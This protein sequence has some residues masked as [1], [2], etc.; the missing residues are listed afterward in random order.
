M[1]TKNLVL[2]CIRHRDNPKIPLMFRAV[3]AVNEKLINHFKLK[4]LENDWEKMIEILGADI[5][6]DG[7]TLGA[8]TTYIPKYAGP[9]FEAI[10]EPNHF[11][12]WGIKPE[13][14]YLGSGREIIFHKNPPLAKIETPDELRKYKFPETGWFDFGTYK[15]VVTAKKESFEEQKEIN[16]QFLKR[17]DIYFINTFCFNSIFM[18]S[19]FMRGF[20]NMLMDLLSNRFFAKTL[21][22]KIGEFYLD[23]TIK[24][25]DAIG[26][27]LDL[28]GIW[29]DF[30]AILE[31]IVEQSVKDNSNL[32]INKV[33]A[34][35][36]FRICEIGY[37][38]NAYFKEKEEELTPKKK[39][40]AMA[41]GRDCGLRKLDESSETAF[42]D[43]YKNDSHCGGHPWEICRGGNST[44]V[45]LYLYQ[46]ENG[47]KLRLA[48]SSR[49]RVVETVKMALAFYLNKIPFIL[50]K[51]EEILRMITGIDFIGIV[52]ETIIPRYCYGF[53]PDDNRIN[54]FMNLGFE[55]AK[56]IIEKSY[57][58]PIKEVRLIT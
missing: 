48:G 27:R 18:T 34:G 15:R 12:I 40:L 22:D 5:F 53:F 9:S 3:P 7:E 46:V 30:V 56:E 51:A 6:S 8:F 16:P 23:F 42:A 35:D 25:L 55:R 38:A 37:N 13:Y 50:E 52:P 45:S 33:S 58:Y 11:F 20:E 19:I 17:S 41:D 24:N 2:N 43:W 54:D 10:Y 29:D 1:N 36:Y 39:Y 14:I 44:H 4:D 21:I 32:I 47:W 26:D 57:W 49:A 31:K 28:Y